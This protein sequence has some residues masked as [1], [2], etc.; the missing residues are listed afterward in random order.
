ME[1]RGEPA[2]RSAEAGAMHVQLHRSLDL[3][4]SGESIESE[5]LLYGC[6]I[7][8]RCGSAQKLKAV[9]A[10]SALRSCH[11][12]EP[13][14]PPRRIYNRL[15]GSVFLLFLLNPGPT[16]IQARDSN[17]GTVTP[18]GDSITHRPSKNR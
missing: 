17:C 14:Q 18:I 8:G 7:D 9:S 11:P 12:A 10:T 6:R 3:L 16:A 1:I 5:R 15:P 13:P 2:R 4:S